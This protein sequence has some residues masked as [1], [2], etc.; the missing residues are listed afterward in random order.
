M[1][2]SQT[3]DQL[4]QKPIEVKRGRTFYVLLGVALL[5]ATAFALQVTI[6]RIFSLIFDY[7][8]VFVV[9]AL[10]VMGSGLGAA[11]GYLRQKHYLRLLKISSP[12]L[13]FSFLLAAW[14]LAQ[15]TT[16]TLSA[17][18]VAFLI[19]P[20]LLI[21]WLTA[22]VYR[23]YG[24]ASAVIYAADLSGAVIGF[25]A[26]FVLLIVF[27]PFGTIILLGG[28]AAFAGYCLL[29]GVGDKQRS[30]LLILAGFAALLAAANIEFK[31]VDYRPLSITQAHPDKT[32]ITVLQDPRRQAS[33]LETRWGAFAQVDLVEIDDP[34]LRY[35]FTDAGAGSIMVRYDP[36]NEQDQLTW[37]RR[38]AASFPF[39][40]AEYRNALII[41]AGAGYDILAARLSGIEDITAVEIN[42]TIVDLTRAHSEFNGGI[43]D[44]PGVNTIV[45]DGRRFVHQNTQP[46]DLIYLNL[47]YSQALQPRTSAL[48]EN[49][50]FTIEALHA[51]WQRLE[52]SGRVAI[53]THNA[54]E[55]VRLL[56][57][58]LTMLQERENMALNAALD[59]VLL[60]TAE[61][62]SNPAVRTSVFILDRTPL[63]E[64]L[65]ASIVD[66]GRQRQL[67]PLYAPHVYEDPLRMLRDGTVTLAT[68]I[69]ENTDYNVFPTTD[70]RPFFYNIER[71]VPRHQQNLLIFTSLITLAYLAGISWIQPRG[72]THE[73]MQVISVLYFAGLGIAFMLLEIAILGRFQVFVGHPVL[74][75]VLTTSGL[76]IGA[77]LGSWFSERIGLAQLPTAVAM[78]CAGVAIWVALFVVTRDSINFL[79]ELPTLLTTAVIIA[80]LLPLGFALGIPF[81]SCLRLA[82]Q[83]NPNCIPLFWGMNALASGTG[84]VLAAILSM[85][86]GFSLTLVL[87][88]AIYVLLGLVALLTWRRVFALY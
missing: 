57:T 44:L 52:D 76:L 1:I 62:A 33:I 31:F 60:L 67:I 41:G 63:V 6:T 83:T 4:A 88:A 69:Q 17:Q 39:T 3:A 38:T 16:S 56:L 81:P 5:A 29:I 58:A 66:Q 77:A 10:G 53:V 32:L 47:V 12:V 21:G 74:S 20:F 36:S 78:S 70:D 54:L 37:L 35:V 19:I 59:H 7:N 40:I 51:Y 79:L 13:A 86:Y 43:L 73:W 72:R 71:V 85:L 68:Y 30:Y 65:S 22:L 8:Y 46:Y 28:A 64:E 9:V 42:D 14:A 50:I 18:L 11:I 82:H 26:G 25:G 84:A 49:Y 80:A 15:H 27:G 23:H 87:A 45:V 2:S 61:Q 75:L 48:A 34:N 55:G 24:K